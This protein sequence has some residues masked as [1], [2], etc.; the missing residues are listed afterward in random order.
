MKTINEIKKD[1]AEECAEEHFE[2]LFEAE[3]E[4]GDYETARKLWN[5]VGDRYV[6][7]FETKTE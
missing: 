6:K 2:V 3:I 7:Q 4:V 1:I 5:E